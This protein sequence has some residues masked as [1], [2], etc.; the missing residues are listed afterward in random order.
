MS[1]TKAL[2]A[3]TGKDLHSLSVEERM[4]LLDE[5]IEEYRG[6]LI[7]RCESV[8]G[9]HQ[10]AED[11]VQDTFSKLYQEFQCPKSITGAVLAWTWR[12][13]FNASVNMLKRENSVSFL[14][15]DEELRA[16]NGLLDSIIQREFL[17]KIDEVVDKLPP[18]Q[19]AAFVAVYGEGL[20]PREVAE[21]LESSP[22]SVRTNLSKALKKVQDALVP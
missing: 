6:P 22:A 3:L 19:R 12:V 5:I 1:G 10:W 16:S 9:D 21:N 2:D 7:A 11:V 14:A 20:K 17:T 4:V 13:A 15:I 18:Q 8:L